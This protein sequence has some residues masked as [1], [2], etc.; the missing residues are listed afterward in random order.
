MLDACGRKALLTLSA[1]GPDLQHNWRRKSLKAVG[2]A[3]RQLLAA[4]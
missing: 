3:I 4:C 1:D 2:A